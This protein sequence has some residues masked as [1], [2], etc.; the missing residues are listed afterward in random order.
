MYYV[1]VIFAK[2]TLM[3]RTQIRDMNEL[4]EHYF[5]LSVLQFC[6]FFQKKW[7][8]VMQTIVLNKLKSNI[9]MLSVLVRL[10]TFYLNYYK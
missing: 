3:L 8:D 7:T 5:T 9:F 1:F 6:F 4:I 10:S 2:K